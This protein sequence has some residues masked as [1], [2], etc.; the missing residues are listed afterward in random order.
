[1]DLDETMWKIRVRDD[2]VY[3]IKMTILYTVLVLAVFFISGPVGDALLERE[4]LMYSKG[5]TLP[6]EILAFVGMQTL[7]HFPAKL[8]VFF[9]GLL[10]LNL[11]AAMAAFLRGV[12]AMQASFEKGRF[13]FFFLQVMPLWKNYVILMGEIL[14]TGLLGWVIYTT[15]VRIFAAILTSEVLPA[16]MDLIQSVLSDM[17]VRGIMVMFFMT[18]IGMV[19]GMSQKRHVQGGDICLCFLGGALVLG[20]MYKIPQYIAYLQTRE[21]VRAQDTIAVFHTLKKFQVMCPFSWLNPYNIY[22]GFLDMK[23]L[24]IYILLATVL[25]VATGFWYCMRDWKEM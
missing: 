1:M 10:I 14:V 5:E 18:A 17:T 19:F 21:M 11:V 15:I 6:S 24:G 7:G 20:N 3:L 23:D 4:I 25:L 9:L 8:E 13:S 2:G 16:E 22:H 12:H